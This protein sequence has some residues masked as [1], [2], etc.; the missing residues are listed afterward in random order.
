MNILKIKE[1]STFEK[2]CRKIANSFLKIIPPEA[3]LKFTTLV[4]RIRFRVLKVDV[5]KIENIYLKLIEDCAHSWTKNDIL[6]HAQILITHDVDSKSCYESIKHICAIEKK[7]N[8]RS[9]FN[10]L[11]NGDY[12]IDKR[13]IEDLNEDAF[14][15]GLH[16]LDH[17]IAI[18]YRRPYVIKKKLQKAL[19]FFPFKID[20]YR[21]P[22]L[23]VSQNLF[24]VLE[25]LGFKFDSSI[26]FFSPYYGWS[27]C[28]FPYRYPDI[29]IIEL[30]LAIQ[31]DFLFRE[32]MLSDND[33]FFFTKK[34]LDE[35]IKCKGTFVF[36]G[37][38]AILIRHLDF[39]KRFLDYV[40][41]QQS[42]I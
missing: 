16:G 9:T 21:S 29:N 12:K 3:K 13:L 23:S 7:R 15:I 31:D 17:D 41:D 27:G 30:P 8:I 6:I 39:Y 35:F 2:S 19:D 22:A 11:T 37:H 28:I 34:I 14:R 26:S 38:P 25:E 4:K 40:K 20:T 42:Q 32:C 33:A 1:P 10:F 36:N 18:A 24:K 5:K